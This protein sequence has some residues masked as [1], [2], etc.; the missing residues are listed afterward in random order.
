MPISARQAAIGVAAGLAGLYAFQ[1]LAR[2]ARAP[3]LHPG[4]AGQ[5]GRSGGPTIVILGAGFAGAAAARTLARKLP[6]DGDA[7]IVLVDQNNFL[8]FTPMLTEVVSGQVDVH[9]IISATRRLSPRVTFLQ[10]HVDAVDVRARRVTLTAGAPEAGIP[11]ARRTLQA[12]QLVI[13]PGSVTNFHHVQGL[14]EHAFT[15][16]TAADATAMH[17]RIIS[18]L[19]RAEVEP[20]AALRRSLLTFVV[21]GGGFSGVETM[22]A[23]NDRVRHLARYYSN[24][25][26]GE[27]RTLLVHPED[28]LLPELSAGLAAYARRELERRGVEV[29]VNM[30][31]AGA[32]ADYVDLQGQPRIS[33]HTLIW[34]AGVTPSPVVRALDCKHGPRHGVVVDACFRVPDCPGVWA[35]GDCAEIPHPTSGQTYAPTA[36]NGM[37]EGAQVA[38]NI[39]ASLRGEQPRPFVYRP[40]GELA[41]VGERTGVASVYGRQFSGLLAWFMWR[42]IYLAKEPSVAKRVRTG[43]DWLLDLAGYRLLVEL[44]VGQRATGSLA[45][46]EEPTAGEAA[47]AAGR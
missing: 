4:G 39:V 38:R 32:G 7:R 8:L 34:T 11:T 6:R 26:P 21:G 47:G 43:V 17:D 33:A 3:G 25:D 9:D 35:V 42:A 14:E 18:L 24:V 19:E 1:K 5:D 16:K 36:Q 31:I 41:L 20:D 27:I 30:R 44:P 22:A 2:P 29:I 13:A 28:R 12:D 23:L 15:I 10:G 45:G 37:R 40:I 46:Q